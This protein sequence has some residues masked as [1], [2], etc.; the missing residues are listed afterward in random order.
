MDLFTEEQIKEATWKLEVGEGAG[1]GYVT[2][3]RIK[4]VGQTAIQE[5]RELINEST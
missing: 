2:T 1:R 5:L 4:Y 3:E